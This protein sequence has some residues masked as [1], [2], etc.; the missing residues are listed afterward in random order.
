MMNEKKDVNLSAAKDQSL[1]VA[2]PIERDLLPI[3]V[4][5][6][7]LDEREHTKLPFDKFP[8][9]QTSFLSARNY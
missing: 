6:K 7:I 8:D 4:S 5:A 9:G 3:L 1:F 2:P